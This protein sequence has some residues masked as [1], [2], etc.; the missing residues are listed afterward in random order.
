VWHV[1]EVRMPWQE[2]DVKDEK[3]SLIEEWMSGD[4]KIAE[5]A[6]QYGVSRKAVYEL[7]GRFEEEGWGCLEERSRAPHHHPN[8]VPSAVEAAVVKLRRRHPRWGPKKLQAR[9]AMDA[10]SVHWPAQSTI[11]TIVERHG[12]VVKRRLRRR[13][14]AGGALGEC[15]QA[16]AVWGLDF[17]GWFRTGDGRRCD[18]LSA[19]DLYSRYLLRLQAVERCDGPSVW[20]VLE[21]AFYEYGLPLAMRSDNGAPFASRAV[22]GL[23][24]LAVQVI[25]AGVTPERIAP[26]KP[27]QNGRHERMHLT[28]KQETASPPAANRRAQQRRFDAFRWTFNHERPH[29]ALDQTVPAT[30]FHPPARPYHGRLRSPD[31]GD[32]RTVRRVR[33]NGEI[34]WR[35]AL[36]FLS[37]CLAGEPVAIVPT[38]H[39]GHWV[40][41]YGP[42][43]LAMLDAAGKLD[44]VGAGAR[45]HPQPRPP[46]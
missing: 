4:W 25:K 9:L 6:R 42:L 5:L 14:P 27:Q 45:A 17:K 37:E 7:T 21:A 36:V 41:V 38:V 12:L 28:V 1:Q 3:R 2:T 32:E 30:H 39:D 33:H 31:Y 20:S 44:R 15:G 24:W 8:A 19:S 16:S 13:V 29:E 23:S 26:G 40:I 35:G 22:G 18:P 43:Q 46:G 34:K 11:A 10:P